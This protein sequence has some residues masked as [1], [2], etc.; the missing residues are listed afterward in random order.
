MEISGS[1]GH[2]DV[3]YDIFLESVLWE[4]VLLK[5]TADTCEPLLLRT[6]GFVLEAVW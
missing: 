1:V 2:P 6:H 3:L 4:D 5:Q